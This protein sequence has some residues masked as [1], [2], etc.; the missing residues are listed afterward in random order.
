MLI[1][2][3]ILSYQRGLLYSFGI[4]KIQVSFTGH[5]NGM[6]GRKGGKYR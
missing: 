6:K 4:L 2:D 1:A 5:F 3:G